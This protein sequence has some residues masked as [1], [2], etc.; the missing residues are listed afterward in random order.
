LRAN[1]EH[2]S[3][4]Q[5]TLSSLSFNEISAPVAY[6][7]AKDQAPQVASIIVAAAKNETAVAEASGESSGE[8]SGAE[9]GDSDEE[10][11]DGDVRRIPISQGDL[12]T[13]QEMM[14]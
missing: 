9:E 10:S 7:A 6:T 11:E 13:L 12:V 3:M 2:A 8:D 14:N 1:C 5:D 4:L